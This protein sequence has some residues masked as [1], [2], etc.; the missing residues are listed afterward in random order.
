MP[1][2]HTEHS[3]RRFR[4]GSGAFRRAVWLLCLLFLALQVLY[5][6]KR[7]LV[8]DEF[9]NA[10]ATH[11]FA[12]QVPYRD[13]APYKTV[14]GYYIQL[15]ALVA[16][17]GTWWPLLAVK[18]QMAAFVTLA[19]AFAALRLGRRFNP[20]A[21]L[22]GLGLLI[23]MSTFAERAAALRLDMLTG[24]LGLA[25]LILLLDRRYLLAGLATGLS[26]LISQ[27]GIF[28]VFAGNVGIALCWLY[29]ERTVRQLRGW[30]AFNLAALAVLVAYVGFWSGWAS[31]EEVIR[32]TFFSHADITFSRL[33]D[34]ML[35]YWS[36]TLS[37]NP[38]FYLLALLGLKRLAEGSPSHLGR[39][40]QVLLAAYGATL[41]GLSAIHR[42]PWPYFFVLLIPTL[43]ILLVAYLDA[44]MPLWPDRTAWHRGALASALVGLGFLLP[45]SRLPANLARDAGFQR[46][47]I[48]LT[49]RLLENDE[50]YFA[51]TELLLDRP[52]A[53]ATLSWLDV[54]RAR[55]LAQ[56]PIYELERLRR[57]LEES[58][59]KLVI[60]N[61]RIYA[62]PTILRNHLDRTYSPWWG[63]IAIYAPT[64]GPGSYRID[65]RFAGT[66]EL[67]GPA[68]GVLTI[69]GRLF[70]AGEHLELDQG[71]YEVES[72]GTFRL[73]Y[74][75]LDVDDYLDPEFRDV[76]SFFP[77]V[78]TY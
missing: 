47:M 14:L 42:Q 5:I 10:F 56:T 74:I 45:L 37:R 23:V 62:L 15:P 41:I 13:F 57:K 43:W 73:R 55:A 58:P 1:T 27:K 46:S 67:V 76:Q 52:Q 50:S 30:L 53:L 60:Y 3:R 78:Y 35:Q 12:E 36:Q 49:D 26:F 51:G 39:W 31:F 2:H 17:E 70:A 64:I 38:L 32:S 66:Y 75:P 54:P 8:M 34:N 72:P 20:R 9:Q 7:P 11:R 21:V 69:D 68:G 48:R 29:A 28:Y 40:R 61:Y 4:A 77:E 6:L 44:E 22:L 24:L 65:L 59:T 63:N 19:L 71:P 18:L 25:S 33:Y 16:L